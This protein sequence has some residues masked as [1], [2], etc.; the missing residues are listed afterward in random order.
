M[1]GEPLFFIRG[2]EL[3]VGG[4]IASY[5]HLF[6]TA[7]LPNQHVYRRQAEQNA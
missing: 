3:P 4:K 7:H 5:Y 1:R 6:E 2:Q